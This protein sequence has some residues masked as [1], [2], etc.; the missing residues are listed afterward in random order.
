MILSFTVS[1]SR[2]I[3]L[4]DYARQSYPIK[5]YPYMSN[6][7]V[8]SISNIHRGEHKV[9]MYTS[10]KIF[11]GNKQHGTIIIPANTKCIFDGYGPNKE[12]RV[13]F[14]TGD[15]K[16][17]SFKKKGGHIRDRYYLVA[18]WRASGGP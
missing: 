11:L 18:D 2:S 4:T 1:C 8:N 17:L 10:S 5:G 12:I 14:Q 13:R 3:S 7:R 6:N 16:Y 15:Q 9:Q